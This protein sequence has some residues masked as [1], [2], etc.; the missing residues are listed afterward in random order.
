MNTINNDAGLSRKEMLKKWRAQ[1]EAGAAP[2][3]RSLNNTDHTAGAN[4]SSLQSGKENRHA[5]ALTE[6]SANINRAHKKPASRS[7]KGAVKRKPF[8]VSLC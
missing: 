6:R 5:G 8:Q 4:A 2:N 1:R 7:K 3:S